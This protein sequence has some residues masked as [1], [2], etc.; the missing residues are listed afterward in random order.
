[1]IPF[2]TFPK[3]RVAILVIALAG[4]GV[5]AGSA[6]SW[7]SPPRTKE[8]SPSPTLTSEETDTFRQLTLFSDVLERVRADYVEP[9][10]DK[11]L[12]EAA[13]NGML[14]SLDPHSGYMDR[15][16][17]SDMKTQT[18][19]EF[20]GLG[21]EVTLDGPLV[22]VISPI[23]DTP[24][25]RAKIQPGDLITRI[26]GKIVTEM[27]LMEAVQK[28][29]GVPGTRVML[30][31]RRGGLTGHT[32][33][34][35][36]TR[37]VIHVKSV[38][39]EPKGDVAYLRITTFNE[40]TQPG[41]DKA[42]AEIDKKIGASLAGY[43]L[44]LRN[45]PGGLL[46]ESILAASRFLPT[47]VV[48][49]ETK[50]RSSD[51]KGTY[52]TEGGNR[53]HGLPV[54]VLVN[55]GSASAAEIVAGAIQD[56]HRGLVVGTRSFGKGSVQTVIPL[57]GGGAIRLTTARYYTPS[58]RSI[59]QLG[60][61]PDIVVQ[62]AKVERLTLRPGL[63]EADLR[64]ALPNDTTPKAGADAD[65]EDDNGASAE[66]S[67]SDSLDRKDEKDG[68]DGKRT[69]PRPLEDYQ[70]ERALDLV[71]GVHFFEAKVAPVSAVDGAAHEPKASAKA[72]PAPEK[73]P[74]GPAKKLFNGK[75]SAPPPAKGSSKP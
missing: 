73:E 34:V 54:V 55:G 25:A 47:G 24:A 46:D 65:S 14:V 12:I 32:F 64:G 20:G 6:T 30:T 56:H 75:T 15:E 39:W 61:E 27:T 23:D 19:G 17:F 52:R 26:D 11:K 51:S 43:V 69:T 10:G 67:S 18:V 3:V 66:P 72:E 48:V 58:G 8:A 63:R 31:L 1:M 59:Q 7:A 35:T 38:R 71:R 74:Q 37:A 29:R 62:P 22:K 57:A 42:F 49:V 45:N 21:L 16:S 9:V 4:V 70:L 68:K 2:L 44:D 33:D 53:T 28:M 50:G 60:I 36:L 41:L 13:L 5:G 40:Q